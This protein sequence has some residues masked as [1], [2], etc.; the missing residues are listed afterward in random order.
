MSWDAQ[1][2]RAYLTLDGSDEVVATFYVPKQ[3]G[4]DEMSMTYRKV[5]TSGLGM[6][7]NLKRNW[8]GH[9]IAR[10]VGDLVA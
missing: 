4:A 6:D 8:R 9:V 7:W 10:G 5:R 3:P 1:A 2:F